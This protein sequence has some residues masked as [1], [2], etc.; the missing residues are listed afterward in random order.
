[1]AGKKY[2]EKGGGSDTICLPSNPSWSNY[3]DGLNGDKARVYCTEFNSE[4]GIFPKAVQSQDLPCAVCLARKN[5]QIVIPGK[6]DCFEGWTREYHGYLAAD[7]HGHPAPTKH[8]CVDFEPHFL[9][10]GSAN[11]DEHLLYLVEVI[12]GSLPCPP[13]VN[14]RELACVVCTI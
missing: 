3:T 7:N 4:D 5:A 14:G 12:C 13:Y 1:M 11:D 6:N 8:I 2:N 10:K 9:P